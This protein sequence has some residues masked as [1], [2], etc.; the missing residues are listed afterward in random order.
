M[1]QKNLLANVRAYY[2]T[3]FLALTTSLTMALTAVGRKALLLD[4]HGAQRKIARRLSVEE[5]RVS[6][7]VKGSNIPTTEVGWRSYRRVQRAIAK[8]LGLRVDEAF[9]AFERGVVGEETV[10][11]T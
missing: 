3:L 8:T 7:V 1:T 2:E 5:S 11:A 6:D 4:H 9:Q 10:A